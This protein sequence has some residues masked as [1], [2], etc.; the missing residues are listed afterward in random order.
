MRGRKPLPA[1]RR[2][3][4]GNAGHRRIPKEPGFPEP[5]REDDPSEL[6]GDRLALREWRRLV[7]ILTTSRVLTAADRGSLVALC[8]EWSR[9]LRATA[10]V[11]RRGMVVRTKTGYPLPNPYLGIGNRALHYC[12]KLWAELGLT[13]SSRTRV[14]P[15]QDDRPKDGFAEFDQPS[16]AHDHLQ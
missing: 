16:P 4:E 15:A 14:H 11:K 7:P 9:Y 3:L 2:K 5:A 10:E 12:T 1:A 8:R 13:P 6:V